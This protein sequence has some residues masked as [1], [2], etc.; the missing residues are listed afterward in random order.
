MK[1]DDGTVP[2]GI[3]KAQKEYSHTKYEVIE[4]TVVNFLK[5]AR[6]RSMAVT[7]QGIGPKK[8]LWLIP[9]RQHLL[10]VRK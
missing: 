6:E 1:N 2:P 3:E 4:T 5:I 9:L 10:P 8:F 7:G